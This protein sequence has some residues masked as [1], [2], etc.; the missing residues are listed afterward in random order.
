MQKRDS[1]ILT[2]MKIRSKS[3]KNIRLKI[4]KLLPFC[5]KRHHDG[6]GEGHAP[7]PAQASA[8]ILNT[9]GA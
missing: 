9:S 5:S 2:D 4:T 1:Y 7:F 8:L 6:G 3:N